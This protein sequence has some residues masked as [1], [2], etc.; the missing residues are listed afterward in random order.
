MGPHIRGWLQDRQKLGGNVAAF[1]VRRNETL[2]TKSTGPCAPCNAPY[3]CAHNGFGA[4]YFCDDGLQ[5]VRRIW[6]MILCN[7]TVLGVRL[8]RRAHT[9]LKFNEGPVRSTIQPRRNPCSNDGDAE[10]SSSVKSSRSSLLSAAEQSICVVLCGFL[11][12]CAGLAAFLW[13]CEVLGWFQ[14]VSPRLGVLCG[15]G[16]VSAGLT[17][18]VWFCVV[19]GWSRLGLLRSC[20]LAVLCDFICFVL[21]SAWSRC[22]LIGFVLFW[23][24]R[25]QFRCFLWFCEFCAGLGCSRCALF[26]FVWFR[27]GLG[28]GLVSAGVVFCT[29]LCTLWWS[30]LLSL[31][32]VW[33]WTGLCRFRCFVLVLRSSV[34]DADPRL[35]T[36]AKFSAGDA[37]PTRSAN[38]IN[39]YVG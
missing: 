10:D 36:D 5:G 32:F 18:F 31:R 27:A 38:N 14:L 26:G 19:L 28:F 25:C 12:V 22:V 13:F 3:T 37:N 2:H 29:V 17:A 21:V 15:F 35:I 7:A 30:R 20:G 6:K 9:Q 23:A 39:I 8:G 34:E 16:L 4:L 11:L 33:F 1:F 24:G